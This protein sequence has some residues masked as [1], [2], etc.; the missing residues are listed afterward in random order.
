M[1]KA[2]FVKNVQGFSGDARLYAMNPKHDGQEFVIVSKINNMYGRETYIF[3]ADA[4]G[5]VT[6]WLEMRGSMRGSHSHNE[7][8]NGIGYEVGGP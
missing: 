3:P 8:L 7:V 5:K 6:D 1:R 4:D 2:T